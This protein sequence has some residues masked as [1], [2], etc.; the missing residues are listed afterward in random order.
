[1]NALDH[2]GNP[3]RDD[4][5][6]AAEALGAIIQ[7]LAALSER[8]R[9]R[10]LHSLVDHDARTIGYQFLANFINDRYLQEQGQDS[11]VEYWR[12]LADTRG[13]VI[14]DNEDKW[15]T[16]TWPSAPTAIVKHDARTR[17]HPS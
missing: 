2:A 5:E 1:M 17:K 12:Y 10:V 13:A 11:A 14:L 7:T 16:A 3:E 9:I 15:L 8:E 4:Q 6:A